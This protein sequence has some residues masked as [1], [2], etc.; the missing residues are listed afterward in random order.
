MRVNSDPCV[1]IEV[2]MR[3][4]EEKLSVFRVECKEVLQLRGSE[5][6]LLQPVEF[7]ASYGTKM[8]SALCTS[9]RHLS[10]S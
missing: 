7:P 4:S 1:K 8:F 2:Y 10:L 5:P 9:A 6:V 3:V